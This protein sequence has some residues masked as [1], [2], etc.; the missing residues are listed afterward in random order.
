MFRRGINYSNKLWSSTSRMFSTKT[1]N[2]G[3]FSKAKAQ[4]HSSMKYLKYMAPLAVMSGLAFSKPESKVGRS[5]AKF[6][7]SII[8]AQEK[9]KAECGPTQQPDIMKSRVNIIQL[10][11]NNPCEDRFDAHQFKSTN[12]YSVAVYDGKKS[13][14][15]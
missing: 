10:P 5:I 6:S 4:S 7:S 3:L 8:R 13:L 11:A 12:G 9:V 14:L 15:I 2:L 1:T